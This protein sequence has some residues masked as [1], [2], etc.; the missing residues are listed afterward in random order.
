MVLLR[1]LVLGAHRRAPARP[2]LAL[3]LATAWLA[4]A[5]QPPE[6]TAGPRPDPTGAAEPAAAAALEPGQLTPADVLSEEVLTRLEVQIEFVELVKQSRFEDAL[7][8]AEQM[9]TLTETEF[10]SPSAELATALSNLAIVQRNLRDYEASKDT[11]LLAIDMYR[12]IEGP[13]SESII[14][15]LI[16]L[17]ANYHATGDYTQALGL[18]QEART[19]NRRSY[20]LLNPDQVD[21]VYHIA[22]TL[23]SMQQYEEAQ[24]QQEDALRL[25]ERVY[26]ADTME[27]LPYLYQY[28]AWLVTTF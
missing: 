11:F 17:G 25:M 14:S 4:A 23:A 1:T 12:E 6:S 22:A 20:G 26:G 19:V 8:L 3:C 27:V 24:L 15:P 9:I 13:F 21:I 16:A 28:A 5:G 7:P 10:G 2:A 18:F